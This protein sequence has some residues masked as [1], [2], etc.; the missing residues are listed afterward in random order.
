MIESEKGLSK[1]QDVGRS[2]SESL[3][4][5]AAVPVSFI[6]TYLTNYLIEQLSSS[7]NKSQN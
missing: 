3:S 6:H 1:R 7:T 2:G 5:M 4:A